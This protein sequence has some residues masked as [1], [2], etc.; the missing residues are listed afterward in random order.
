MNAFLGLRQLKLLDK[1]IKIRNYNYKIFN[2]ILKK[3]EKNFHLIMHKNL[4]NISSFSLP[5]I[6]K[7][8][9]KLTKFKELLLKKK[10]EYRPLISGDLTKQPYLKKYKKK[11]NFFAEIIHSKGIYIGNNQFINRKKILILDN[12]LKKLFI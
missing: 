9:K 4:N 5:F 11:K 8:K 3:Y 7:D 2:E 6:F 12:I 1:F 10:I